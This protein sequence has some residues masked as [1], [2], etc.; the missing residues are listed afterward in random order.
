MT[1][2]W[3]TL[4]KLDPYIYTYSSC[5]D[6]YNLLHWHICNLIQFRQ[7]VFCLMVHVLSL[8][9]SYGF[10]FFFQHKYISNHNLHIIFSLSKFK[11]RIRFE[12]K[13]VIRFIKGFIATLDNSMM[14]KSYFVG[15]RHLAIMAFTIVFNS[16]KEFFSII[17]ATLYQIVDFSPTLIGDIDN[18]LI[19]L[20]GKQYWFITWN[21]WETWKKSIKLLNLIHV[22]IL[23]HY[24]IVIHWNT[25]I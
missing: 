16:I 20:D 8:C 15:E 24:V 2:F 7:F 10:K 9:G 5:I 13:F 3:Y 17:I 6:T 12:H 25:Q 1:W 11:H 14:I 22:V 18:L 4:K 21:L 19:N 23:I